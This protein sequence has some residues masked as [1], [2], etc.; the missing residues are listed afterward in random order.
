VPFGGLLTAGLFSAG[1]SI[2]G[3]IAGRHAAGTAAGQQVQ[4]GQEAIDYIK[5]I[6]GPYLGAG[7]TSIGNIMDLLNSGKFGAGSNEAAPKF[8]GTFTP[9]TK[10]ELQNFPGYQFA[11]EQ[12]EKGILSGAAA[13]GG[14]ISGGTM[15]ALSGFN[16]NLAENTY[17]Q[18]FQNAMQTYQSGL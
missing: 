8:T 7:S 11:R 5:Q 12:G 17:Q 14:N 10:E 9:P 2:F 6:M 16:Q 18:M 4:G 3:G 1:S 13:A 15:R